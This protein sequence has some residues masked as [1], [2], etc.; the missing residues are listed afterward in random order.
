MTSGEWDRWNKKTT[1]EDMLKLDVNYLNRQ[2]LLRTG[3][4]ATLTWSQWDEQIG[5]IQVCGSGSWITLKYRYADQEDVSQMVGLTHSPCHFGGKRPWFE[6]PNCGR[7]AGNLLGGGRRFACRKCFDVVYHTQQC[8]KM[9][10]L[11]HRM[12][13]LERHLERQGLRKRTVDMLLTQIDELG[14]EVDT[15]FAA[16]FGLFRI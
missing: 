11:M 4:V 6:C 9:E 3:S 1:V 13:K 5:S 7:R 16:R 8:G 10:R 2:G 12:H 15:M 14:E